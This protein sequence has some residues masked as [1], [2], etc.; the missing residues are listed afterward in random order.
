MEFD[1]LGLIHSYGYPAL[2][3]WTAVVEGES[4]L[5]LAGFAASLGTLS[6]PVVIAVAVSAAV[7]GDQFFFWLGRKKGAAFIEAR[8][9][10][11]RR[12]ERFHEFMRRYRDWAIVGSR[13]AYGLR[14]VVPTVIG[15]SDIS[16]TRFTV[17][18]AVG[19]A[20]WGAGFALL[21]YFFGQAV[22][23]VLGEA[24]RFAVPALALLV[25]VFFAIN[26]YSRSRRRGD[27]A[28][29]GASTP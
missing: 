11:H 7:A 1:L 25:L 21:G 9:E 24:R 29:R 23:A 20:L 28:K 4:A 17:L 6:L 15:T 27:N 12:A 26:L 8:P 18:N 5:V 14:V 16:W 22:E 3:V 10:W 2:F 13:F 19:A